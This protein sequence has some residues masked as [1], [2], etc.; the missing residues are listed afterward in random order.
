MAKQL[1]KL[2][3]TIQKEGEDVVVKYESI[4]G[5]SEDSQLAKFAEK[6][7]S[8]D[9]TNQQKAEDLYD[10]IETECKSDESI[11]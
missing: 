8:L 3:I 9:E 6:I 11:S 1:S 2:Q 7:L 4:I 10:A 5:S